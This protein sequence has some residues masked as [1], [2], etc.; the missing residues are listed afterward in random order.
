VVFVGDLVDRGP[1]SVAVVQLVERLMEAGIAQAI[2][3]NHELNL[4]AGE[5]KEGNGWFRGDATDHWQKGTQRFAFDSRMASE[6]ERREVERLLRRLPLALER[7]DLRVVH[8]CWS[9]AAVRELQ[10]HGVT[11]VAAFS[12]R[13]EEEILAELERDGVPERA[14]QQRA[15]FDDLRVEANKPTYH[16]DAVVQEDLATQRDNPVKVLTSGVE[17]EVEV[18]KHFFTGGRWRFVQRH[19]WWRDPVERPTVV[20]HYWRRRAE[21][22]EGKVDV[23]DDLHPY[24]WSGHVYC[25]DYSVGRRFTERA[26]NKTG[27]FDG[28]LAALRWP[29]RVLLFDDGDAPIP[30]RR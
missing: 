1:D 23:W 7:D 13:R 20:G 22:I 25:V 3:G 30:T 6:D 14:K 8:A 4:L 11:D 28:G 15:Q 21:A 16:L 29:E 12:A 9:D 17:V 5:T 18:G 24:A 2:L 19:R 27:R 10:A 26:R